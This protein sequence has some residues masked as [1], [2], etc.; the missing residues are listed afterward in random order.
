MSV[1][2]GHWLLIDAVTCE[3][4]FI[5]LHDSVVVAAREDSTAHYLLL[6]HGSAIIRLIACDWPDVVQFIFWSLS[7]ESRERALE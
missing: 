5:F 2:N 7:E 6:V 3:D 1:L 4:H